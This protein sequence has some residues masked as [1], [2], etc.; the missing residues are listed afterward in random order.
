MKTRLKDSIIISLALA[1]M[2][3]TSGCKKDDSTP[4]NPPDGNDAELITTVKLSFVDSSGIE[5]I[6][7]FV[8]SVKTK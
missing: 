3:L 2:A 7:Q 8:F 5:P 4:Q 6:R 1:S